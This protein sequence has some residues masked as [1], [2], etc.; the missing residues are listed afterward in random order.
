MQGKYE[1]CTEPFNDDDDYDDE[2]DDDDDDDDVDDD[3]DD[4]DDDEPK[5]GAL[6][7]ELL[8]SSKGETTKGTAAVAHL[9]KHH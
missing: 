2:D 7:F 3:D 4:V 8:N 9:K 5:K 6:S 1:Y